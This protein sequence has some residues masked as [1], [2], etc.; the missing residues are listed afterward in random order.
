MT[1]KCS[2]CYYKKV[3]ALWPVWSLNFSIVLSIFVY[4]FAQSNSDMVVALFFGRN[5]VA[6][7]LIF[8]LM[9]WNFCIIHFLWEVIVL[10]VWLL[11]AH[12]LLESHR[13]IWNVHSIFIIIFWRRGYFEVLDAAHESGVIRNLSS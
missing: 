11:I 13:Q 5:V 10:W 8:R 2:V 9:L 6:F 1:N 7:R 3:H 4:V 12:N